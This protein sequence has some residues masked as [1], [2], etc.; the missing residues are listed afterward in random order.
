MCGQRDGAGQ[1]TMRRVDGQQAQHRHNLSYQILNK[2]DD[3]DGWWAVNFTVHAKEEITQR[4]GGC[5]AWTLSK[6]PEN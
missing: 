6:Y 1:E 5:Q 4:M 3:G 2:T